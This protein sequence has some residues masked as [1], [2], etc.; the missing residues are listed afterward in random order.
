VGTINN[1]RRQVSVSSA[2][3]AGG[4]CG[5]SLA[6]VPT[7][8]ERPPLHT[9]NS[10]RQLLG[11]RAIKVG[12]VGMVTGAAL[13]AATAGA[14]N[15]SGG[16]ALEVGGA[17]A[18]AGLI[19]A[20]LGRIKP[21]GFAL[22]DSGGITRSL[23]KMAVVGG[24]AVAGTAALQSLDVD[25]FSSKVGSG[26]LTGIIGGSMTL[27]TLGLMG[28]LRQP[29]RAE[30]A[31][32]TILE[33]TLHSLDG[34]TPASA[35]QFMAERDA[36][37]RSAFLELPAAATS[38]SADARWDAVAKGKGFLR[39]VATTADIAQTMGR[40]GEIAIR[41]PSRIYTSLNEAA[42]P[43]ARIKLTLDRFRAAMAGP[44]GPYG[45][46]HVISADAAGGTSELLPLG[47]EHGRRGN[48][49]TIMMQTAS[50]SPER[51]FFAT[52]DM[53]THYEQLMRGIKKHIDSMPGAAAERPK[54]VTSG[55]CL[56]TVPIYKARARNG[57]DL[58][59]LGI[60]HAIL[61]V[62]PAMSRDVRSVIGKIDRGDVAGVHVRSR[63][64]VLDRLARGER[65]PS[66]LVHTEDDD[67][68]R[69]GLQSLLMR[70]PMREGQYFMPVV[71]AAAHYLDAGLEQPVAGRMLEVG[72]RVEATAI[73]DA[74][75]GAGLGMTAAQMDAVD[76]AGIRF[77]AI[78]GISR[79]PVAN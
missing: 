35:K 18:G 67:P 55:L 52:D 69:I 39:G 78:R 58:G 79:Q 30:M 73:A 22:R 64:E 48:V 68:L 38:G 25:P 5:A 41:Q 42:D 20:Q 14:V 65:A 77:N 24:S 2:T 71:S 56:G 51:A 8:F 7:S 12:L 4:V 61:P 10:L 36:F 28:A 6:A 49:V 70:F 11:A 9:A 45:M 53:S 1:D 31:A 27:G 34:M 76:Q 16:D 75:F 47:I 33:P 21:A 3:I 72:H 43:G 74:N 44:D 32:R 59:A 40:D 60:S 50:T 37:A 62:G 19:A 46:V 54:V 15:L 63:Q 66:M 26:V 23:G 17:I 57:G 13:T 29:P